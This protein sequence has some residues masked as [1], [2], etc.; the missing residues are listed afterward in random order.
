MIDR[1][2]EY[3]NMVKEKGLP[4]EKSSEERLIIKEI[5]EINKFKKLMT[6]GKIVVAQINKISEELYILKNE[7]VKSSGEKE[8]ELKKKIN[9][10]DDKYEAL[11]RQGKTISDEMKKEIQEYSERT[12][13][14]SKD[15][16]KNYEC[17]K[18][19][20]NNIYFCYIRNF[21]N[22]VQ[23]SSSI[24]SEIKNEQQNK[25]IRDT[26]NFLGNLSEEQK[27]AI[28]NDPGYVSELMENKL[29]MGNAHIQLQNKV[30]DL[31][32]RHKDIIRLENNINN[33]HKLFLD[34]AILVQQQGEIVDNIAS[35]ISSAK[36]FIDKGVIELNKAH[37]YQKSARKKKC[38]ILIIVIV[39]LGVILG[40]VLGTQLG[41]A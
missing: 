14:L 40:P 32:E 29:T 13:I 12:N 38:C 28:I 15:S 31:E 7:I 26:E 10:I 25:I 37:E 19:T 22:S 17:E 8:K 41:K 36:D 20:L 30:K 18:R 2:E 6:E 39:I 35:N 23:Y 21:E 9:E 11:R 27:V 33:M 1:Y 3:R 4:L 5:D 16:N 34:L 24:L